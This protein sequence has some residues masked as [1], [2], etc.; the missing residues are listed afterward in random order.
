MSSPSPSSLEE[1]IR[2]AGE[3]WIIDWFSPPSEA[4]DHLRQTLAAINE[5][6]ANGWG[7]A[8]Q[9]Y[10]RRRSYVSMAAIRSASKGFSRRS[11]GRELPRCCSW[12]GGSFR[13]WKFGMCNSPT[14]GS[15][16]FRSGSFS[17]HLTVNKTHRMIPQIFRILPFFDT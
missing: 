8:R 3:S 14:S 17:N 16:A 4:I 12:L 1:A 9:I 15:R 6:G 11:V 7:R 5:L 13:E 2:D 10:P